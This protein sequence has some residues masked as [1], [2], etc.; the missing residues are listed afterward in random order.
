MSILKQITE[1]VRIDLEERMAEESLEDLKSRL[2]EAPTMVNFLEAFRRNPA[3]ISEIKFASPSEG[4]IR[5][6]MS[7]TEVAQ[8]YIDNGCAALSILTERMNFQGSPVYITEVRKK[9][10]KIPILMKDFIVDPYQIFEAR[11]LGASAILLIV[12]LLSDR[13]LEQFNSLAHSLELSTL[14][15]VHN[16]E[17]LE[18]ALAI[19]PSVLGVNNRNLKTLETSLDV[20]E[21]LSE[22][23]PDN[24]L[25]I[26]ESGINN[27]KDIKRLVEKSYKGFLVGTSLMKKPD[28]GIALRE[29]MS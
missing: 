1:D 17:E 26:S 20:S 19:N 23:I 14:V 13:E 3:L 12:A 27:S 15:E 7:P 8:G 18:R 9:F 22:K 24:I 5:D 2:S 25:S 10:P 29:L 4:L 16:E 21:K 6:D 11:L 28:P